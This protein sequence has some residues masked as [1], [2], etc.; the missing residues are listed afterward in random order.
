[1]QSNLAKDLNVANYNVSELVYPKKENYS[2]YR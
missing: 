2:H 1:M